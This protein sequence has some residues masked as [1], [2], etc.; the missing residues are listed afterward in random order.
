MANPNILSVSS[1]YGSTVSIVPLTPV[2]T[3]NIAATTLTVNTMSSGNVATNQILTGSNITTGTFIVAQLSATNPATVNATFTQATTGANTIV[4]STYTTGSNSSLFVGQFVQPITGIPVNTFVTAVNPSANTITISNVTTGAVSGT[5][6]LH[7]S[8]GL[9]TYSVN[10]SQT[11]PNTA[12]TVTNTGTLWTALTPAVST[13]NKINSIVA[14]NV[15][16]SAATITVSLNNSTG[17]ANNT[18]LIY[19][20]PVPVNASAVI[21]DKS[22]PFYL[23]ENQS[24]VVTSGT[25]GA[26]E[27]TAS[28]EA[29]T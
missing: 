16:G 17:S 29:I 3:A 2:F 4:L 25:S 11:V 19:Q 9:G 20:L 8:G 5:A 10:N 12:V 21:I 24:V 23:N 15:S 1:I 27:V 14:T 13:I 28:Y 18:R 26:I 6:N 7:S 22:T